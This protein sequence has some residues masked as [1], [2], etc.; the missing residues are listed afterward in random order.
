MTP[1]E[2]AWRDDLRP[3]HGQ[4]CK[5]TLWEPIALMDIT[6]EPIPRK[7]VGPGTGSFDPSQFQDGLLTT[8]MHELRARA[9]H[10]AEIVETKASN[11]KLV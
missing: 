3:S 11:V 4:G 1:A 10:I 2:R 5:R 8:G 6:P 7:W 9:S